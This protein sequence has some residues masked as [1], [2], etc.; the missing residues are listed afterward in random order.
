MKPLAL[1]AIA[2]MAVAA[3]AHQASAQT[4]TAATAL[5]PGGQTIGGPGF[6]HGVGGFLPV[7]NA[8]TG[9]NICATIVAPAGTSGSIFVKLVHNGTQVSTGAATS[10]TTLCGAAETEVEVAVSGTA[11]WRV[12][13]TN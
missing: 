13:R 6:V 9:L 3:W 1:A 8:H 7:W 11:F 12:D 10:A 4:A 5:P 2:A